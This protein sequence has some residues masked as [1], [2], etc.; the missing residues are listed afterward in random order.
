MDDESLS[1]LPLER[2]VYPLPRNIHAQL[3]RELHK[4]GAKVVGFDIMFIDDFPNE[5]PELADAMREQGVVVSGVLPKITRDVPGDERYT[6]SEVAAPLRPFVREVSLL[7]QSEY[8]VMWIYPSVVD[9]Q[10]GKRYFHMSAALASS[11]LGLNSYGLL[12]D[13]FEIGSLKAPVG[14]GGELYVRFTGPP[15]TF[16]PIPYHE[17]FSGAW[18]QTRGE[19]FFKDKIVL[20][21]IVNQFTDRHLTPLGEMQ[22]VETLAQETQS[23]LSSQ[24]ITHA[25][26]T[27]SYILKLLLSLVLAAA[28][29]KFGI[30]KGLL[31]ALAEAALWVVL[32]H[33]L[34]VQRGLWLDTV[35]PIGTL[36]FV[37]AG[38]TG[39]ETARI[40]R[41]FQRFMPSSVADQMLEANPGESVRSV[42][43][44]ITVVFCDIRDSTKLGEKLPPEKLEELLQRYFIA[45]EEAAMRLGTELD[46]F[47]GDEIML[48]F[49]QRSGFEDHAIRG[50]EWAFAIHDAARKITQ[51]GLA[52]DIGFRVGVGVC[53]GRARLGLMGAKRRVQHT[54]IGDVVNTASRLQNATKDVNRGTLVDETTW[55]RVKHKFSGEDLGEIVVK[56]KQNPVRIFCPIVESVES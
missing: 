28:I 8:G 5:D 43:K 54:V 44:E 40:R 22:G 46:K 14:P 38:F 39:Y 12:R 51:A 48:F 4:A 34:F 50:V 24:W 13:T 41:V 16:K 25:S 52:A 45:G 7:V 11:Y 23:I 20:V 19:N 31:I 56:G 49:E 6:F 47:V 32:A 55:Q 9:E 2:P 3:L 10:D 26:E 15:G 42:E 18:R 35:E 33:R 27:W 36:A 30:R 37:L 29:A 53:T 17:V 1:H 21:G